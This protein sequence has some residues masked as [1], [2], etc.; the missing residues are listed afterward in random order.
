LNQK[1]TFQARLEKSSNV[2]VPKVIRRQFKIEQEQ[3]LKVSVDFLEIGNSCQFFYAKIMKDGRIH[4][5]KVQLMAMHSQEA[6]L[7]GQII[8]VTLEPA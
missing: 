4:I 7:E 3:T 1:V 2:Q 6:S 8:E 5:P